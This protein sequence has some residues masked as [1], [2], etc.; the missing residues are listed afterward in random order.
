MNRW[1]VAPG[2]CK[3][4]V[5]ELALKGPLRCDAG[6]QDGRAWLRGR[7]VSPPEA[8]FN[9]REKAP[10]PQHPARWGSERTQK[11]FLP[12]KGCRT[13]RESGTTAETG[14]LVYPVSVRDPAERG[15]G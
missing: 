13:R 11:D 5:K 8:E 15:M 4:G 9:L 7:M 3:P 12:W 2:G 14:H 10:L 1:A 6:H